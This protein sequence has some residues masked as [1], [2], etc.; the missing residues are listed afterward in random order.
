M[1]GSGVGDDDG[2]SDGNDDD[3]ND[4]DDDDVEH[5]VAG[6]STRRPRSVSVVARELVDVA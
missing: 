4:E 5:V 2:D 6:D 1:R 3:D